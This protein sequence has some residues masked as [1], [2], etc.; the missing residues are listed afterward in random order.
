MGKLNLDELKSTK[1]SKMLVQNAE[2]IK[3]GV[4]A[5]DCHNG[6]KGPIRTVPSNPTPTIGCDRLT[7]S[8]SPQ[9]GW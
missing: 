7:G 8:C 9:S 2:N 3:G 6:V 5:A 4:L 1:L